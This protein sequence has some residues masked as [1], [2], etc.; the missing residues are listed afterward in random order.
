LLTYHPE[1]EHLLLC[2]IG[3]GWCA[4]VIAGHARWFL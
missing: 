2:A 4:I 1:S 3:L